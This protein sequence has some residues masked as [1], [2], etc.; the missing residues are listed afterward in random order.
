[1]AAADRV[2]QA[3]IVLYSLG[4]CSLGRCYRCMHAGSLD[5]HGIRKR[6]CSSYKVARQQLVFQR[7]RE[8]V[9]VR[10]CP[11]IPAQKIAVLSHLSV[12]CWAVVSQ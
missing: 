12:H 3:N 7:V 2:E 8:G 1:M 4:R 5:F 6:R 10:L 9:R 11:G